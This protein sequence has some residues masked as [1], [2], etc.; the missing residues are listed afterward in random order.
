MKKYI[1]L[2]ICAALAFAACTPSTPDIIEDDYLG[3]KANVELSAEFIPAEG[4]TIMAT[5]H[6]S[7]AFTVAIPKTAGWLSCSQADS[8]L[9]FKASATNSAVVRYARVSIIDKELN[10][11]VTS[12]DIRQAGTQKEIIRKP[13]GVSVET[14]E[15]KAEDTSASF[16]VKGDVAWK[17]SSSNP[18]FVPDPASGEG[19]G[20]V[21]LSF[22]ANTAAEEVKVVITVSTEDESAMPNS[23]GITLTQAAAKGGTAVKPPV[24]TVL[25]EWE[26]D[27]PNVEELRKGNFEQVSSSP[28]VDAPGNMGGAYV[29]ANVSGNGRIEY[30]NGVDKSTVK[31]KTC[32]KRCIGSRGEP[33]IYGTWVG[34][35][36]TWTAELDQPLAAGT[37]FQL[38]FALRPS[39]ESVMKYWKCEYLDG[40]QWVE[41]DTIELDFR[42]SAAGTASDPKQINKFIVETATLTKDTPY[43]QFRFTC[44]QNAQCGN[45]SPLDALKAN[46][47][48][49]FAGKWSDASE[50]NKYLQVPENPKIVVVE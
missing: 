48:L 45:G 11:S 32:V 50:D 24:G 23:F 40:D 18:A 10:I 12:F 19:A 1:S 47:V 25:A 16:S 27:T 36:F 39:T 22:P 17:V 38:N 20:T 29:P 13:F 37:K 5:V 8:V 3:H 14:L 34:D 33:C 28:E 41:L 26:F 43:A 6:R 15:V 4:G 49:R 44:T 30:Y 42:S 9:T 21:N 7:P 46:H 31:T 2:I 35:W